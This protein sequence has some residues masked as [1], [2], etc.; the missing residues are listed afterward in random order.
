MPGPSSR[1]GGFRLPSDRTGPVPRTPMTVLVN[2]FARA[3]DLVG[4]DRVALELGP[5]ADVAALRRALAVSHPA[6]AP[7]V[8]RLLIA[9][10]AQY[11]AEDAPLR[12]DA[13]I[14]CFP[15]VSGG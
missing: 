15:P 3:R 13:E 1:R 5:G 7:L 11:A 6:L 2:L 4:A 10:D 8:P 12:A 14:A 9:L